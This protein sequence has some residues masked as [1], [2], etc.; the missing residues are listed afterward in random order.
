MQIIEK[1]TTIVTVKILSI[2]HLISFSIFYYIFFSGDFITFSYI[3]LIWFS[4]F[5]KIYIHA[6][7]CCL[8][9]VLFS[10]SISCRHGL[11]IVICRSVY[12]SNPVQFGYL[13]RR[14]NIA[15]FIHWKLNRKKKQQQNR[16][17]HEI[18]FGHSSKT[19]IRNS[20]D[21]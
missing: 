17:T 9:S 6:Q 7:C 16:N 13:N 19:L 11:F 4:V 20:N 14:Q 3:N 21:W 1:K 18:S 5:V 10:L 2:F 15:C 12:E 8:L